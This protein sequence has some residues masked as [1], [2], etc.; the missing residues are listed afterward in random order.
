MAENFGLPI[1]M[2]RDAM[3]GKEMPDGLGYPEQILYMCLRMLYDQYRKK[4]ID[5]EVAA[6]EKKKLLDEYRIYKFREQMGDE[7]VAQ[8]KQTELARAEYRKN[9]TLENADKLLGSIDGTVKNK[10]WAD[11]E[12]KGDAL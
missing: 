3:N 9:R 1:E 10:V 8:I 12:E 5:R 2:E 7:W 4:I 11:R 6:R